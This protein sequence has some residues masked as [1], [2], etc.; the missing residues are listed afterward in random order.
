MRYGWV[1]TSQREICY[2]YALLCQNEDGPG[3]VKFGHSHD[4]VKRV[5][6][7]K[8]GC[9]IKVRYLAFIR[10]SFKEKALEVE[11][12]LHTQFNDR[13]TQGEW[14]SFDFTSELD[15]QVFNKGC[16]HVFAYHG[17]CLAPGE[18]WWEKVDL[19]AY[20]ANLSQRRSESAKRAHRE[21][22]AREKKRKIERMRALA[23]IAE[24]RA[25]AERLDWALKEEQKHRIYARK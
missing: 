10:A 9:P 14:F 8:V 20:E 18:K 21:K 7:I 5:H 11:R 17:N 3:Y 22:D 13:R 15:K 25:H 16:K 24:E 1:P 23:Q 19:E 12:A 6:D 4:V 2:V